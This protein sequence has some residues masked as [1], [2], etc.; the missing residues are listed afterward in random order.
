MKK[1]YKFKPVFLF[2]TLALVNK[3]INLYY[4]YSC[5]HI[6]YFFSFS[7]FSFFIYYFIFWGWA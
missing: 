7:F 1:Y 4:F 6:F 5:I 3:P 2:L